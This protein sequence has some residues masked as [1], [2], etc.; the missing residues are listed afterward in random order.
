MSTFVAWPL[1]ITF[2]ACFLFVLL[3]FG[4]W[5]ILANIHISLVFF[6]IIFPPQHVRIIIYLIFKA[7]NKVFFGLECIGRGTVVI[8]IFLSFLLAS[9]YLFYTI[10]PV[11][12]YYMLP[13]CGWVSVATALQ[14]SIYFKNKK[15][16][17]K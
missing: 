11:A 13:T 7:W 4:F 14:Y 10:D 15:S 6:T 5:L 9:T 12:G 8:S 3:L 2:F 1:N 16:I 17:K